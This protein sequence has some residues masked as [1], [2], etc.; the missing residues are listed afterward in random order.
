MRPPTSHDVAVAAG[1]SQPT[2]SRALRGDPRVAEL[3]R[4]RVTEAARAL[5][6]VP[7]DRGRS[8]STRRTSRIGVVVEEVDNPFYLELL[9]ALQVGLE[10]AGV[11]TILLRTRHDDVDHL[12]DGSIDGAVLTATH[13]DAQAPALLQARGLPFVLLNRVLDD[14]DHP[15]C[16]VDNVE[17]ARLLASALH[18][19]GH[20]RVAAVFGPA[21]TSTGRDRELGARAELALPDARVRRGPFAFATGRDAALELLAGDRA[22]RP[23]ALMCG[24]D[25]IALG[26][27]DACRILGLRVP[28]DVSVVGFDDIAM[29]GWETFR[30]TTV[31]QDLRR[32]AAIAVEMVLDPASRRRVVL[33]PE[34]VRRDTLGP[35]PA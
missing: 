19:V 24:N 2:V 32:M 18:A 17:G 12:V 28:G 22:T 25:V 31:R 11:R 3:T 20:E 34:L 14:G 8:L 15:S 33:P 6:Y 30:L 16:S 7:S 4:V 1:V 26:A 35:P 23:T 9:D 29:A 5:G 27:L 13:L 10:A 21:H